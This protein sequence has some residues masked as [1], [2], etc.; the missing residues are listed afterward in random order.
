MSIGF[1]GLG[2]LGLCYRV[3]VHGLLGHPWARRKGAVGAGKMGSRCSA[4][5]IC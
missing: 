3:V 2:L 5:L 1:D 4:F